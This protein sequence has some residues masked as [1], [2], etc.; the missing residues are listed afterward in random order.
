[1]DTGGIF[2]LK[3]SVWVSSASQKPKWLP[4]HKRI[5]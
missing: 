3:D 2:F 1:M 4:L 5:S